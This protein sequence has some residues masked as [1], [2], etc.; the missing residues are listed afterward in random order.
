MAPNF[1]AVV[2]VCPLIQTLLGKRHICISRKF[3]S[4]KLF[5]ADQ[6]FGGH[7]AFA[8]SDNEES[9]CDESDNEVPVLTMCLYFLIHVTKG[10][11][12]F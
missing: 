1:M 4:T 11:H 10:T 8:S 7:S 2:N 5:I 9:S 12:Y 3:Y 6:E